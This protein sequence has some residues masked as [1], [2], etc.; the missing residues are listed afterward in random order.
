MYMQAHTERHLF[1]HNFKKPGAHQL[2]VP[3]MIDAHCVL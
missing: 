1:K 3:D 2:C